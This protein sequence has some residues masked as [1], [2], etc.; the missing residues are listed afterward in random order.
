[1]DKDDGDFQPWGTF[2]VMLVMAVVFIAM[3]FAL[4]AVVFQARG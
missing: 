2:A 1:M 3:W 4:Y